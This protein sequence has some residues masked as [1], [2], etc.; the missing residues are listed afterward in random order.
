MQGARVY[1]WI[2]HLTS[3]SIGVFGLI[4]RHHARRRCKR[5]AAAAGWIFFLC[6]I[7]TACVCACCRLAT[8]I[9]IDRF[10]PR[11]DWFCQ[12][13]KAHPDFPI[14]THPRTH[15]STRAHTPTHPH[16]PNRRA[17]RRR[18]TQPAPPLPNPPRSHGCHRSRLVLLLFLQLRG[19]VP[20]AHGGD[21]RLHLRVH[22]AR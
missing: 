16:R 19:H 7:M 22:G 21:A 12:S 17:T 4:G 5:S 20:E 6:S 9:R 11:F 8:H 15:N 14:H 1:M 18:T 13:S 2:T 10:D 3:D